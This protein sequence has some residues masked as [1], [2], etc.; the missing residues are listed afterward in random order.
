MVVVQTYGPWL[1]RL[2]RKFARIAV[3]D[4]SLIKLSLLAYSWAE[5]RKRSGGSEDAGGLGVGPWDPPTMGG[6]DRQGA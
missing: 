5:Y 4:A 3:V 2:G 1:E 6:H